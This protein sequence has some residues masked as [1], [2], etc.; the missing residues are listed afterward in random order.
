[1]VLGGGILENEMEYRKDC[2]FL[3][4]RDDGDLLSVILISVPDI[5][6][7][8]KKNQSGS[9]CDY[10]HIMLEELYKLLSPEV[11]MEERK[12]FFAD[13]NIDSGGEYSMDIFQILRKELAEKDE[14]LAKEREEMAKKDK[15]IAALMAE[16]AKLQANPQK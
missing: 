2:K 5:E 10:N 9:D 1:M 11:T 13:K 15:T 3:I 6:I 7:A 16:L 14:K 8:V 4:Q 12:E